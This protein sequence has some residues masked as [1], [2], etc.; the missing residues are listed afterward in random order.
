MTLDFVLVRQDEKGNFW[1][2][3]LED[4]NGLEEISI[5]KGLE[6]YLLVDQRLEPKLHLIG[7]Y[8]P[9]PPVTIYTDI[10][11]GMY[12]SSQSK[13]KYLSGIN[14]QLRRISK[15][16]ENNGCTHLELT[17]FCERVE[18][19]YS[20][21]DLDMDHANIIISKEDGSGK[22]KR[23]GS[24]NVGKVIHKIGGRA[25]RELKD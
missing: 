17:D 24:K 20:Q 10:K 12:L 25:Y 13:D 21:T 15:F 16:A 23:L 9:N 8:T 6:K 11:Q 4:F 7:S 14:A 2:V 19:R 1:E 22:I 5:E 3:Q 18:G